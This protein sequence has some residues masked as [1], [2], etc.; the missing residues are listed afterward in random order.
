MEFDAAGVLIPE[1]VGNPGQIILG[2]AMGAGRLF[3]V[4]EVVDEKGF[5]IRVAF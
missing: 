1:A 5:Y 3:Q 4:Y 2:A